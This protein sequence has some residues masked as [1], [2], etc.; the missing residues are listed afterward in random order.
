MHY[1]GFT[2]YMCTVRG[3]C[4]IMVMSIHIIILVSGTK[5]EMLAKQVLLGEDN[6]GVHLKAFRAESKK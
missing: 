6:E 3:G 2:M 4:R 5:Q 1:A